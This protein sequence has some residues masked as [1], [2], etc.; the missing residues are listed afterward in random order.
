MKKSGRTTVWSVT[1]FTDVRSLMEGEMGPQ[2]AEEW[3]ERGQGLF[4]NWEWAQGRQGI[5]C[6]WGQVEMAPETGRLHFQAGCK[7]RVPC[8]L[9]MA[10][11]MFGES[12]PHMEAAIDEGALLNYCRKNHSA[13]SAPVMVINEAF[14]AAGLSR[15]LRANVKPLLSKRDYLFVVRRSNGQLSADVNLLEALFSAEGGKAEGEHV[16]A[17][18]PSKTTLANIEVSY[19][20][21]VVKKCENGGELTERERLFSF[22]P[23]AE[24]IVKEKMMAAESTERRDVKCL[25]LLGRPGTGKS[26]IANRLARTICSLTHRPAATVEFKKTGEAWW[27]PTIETASVAVLEEF[28]GQWNLETFNKVVDEFPYLA[29]YKGGNTYAKYNYVIITTNVHPDEWFRAE[30]V[31]RWG[32]QDQRLTDI[33]QSAIRSMRR[34][35]G[36]PNDT[37]IGKMIDFD[38][39]KWAAAA[40]GDW[41]VDTTEIFRAC[42]SHFD[43]PW[44]LEPS[45]RERIPSYDELLRRDMQAVID[46]MLEEQ[47]ELSKM[48]DGDKQYL[49]ANAALAVLL[50]DFHIYIAQGR[51]GVQKRRQQL[52]DPELDELLG[53]VDKKR[54]KLILPKEAVAPEPEAVEEIDHGE[55]LAASPFAF[56][57]DGMEHEEL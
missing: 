15:W 38:D 22:G 54:M 30:I 52:R 17:P 46:D 26:T 44:T 31:D 5:E 18:P 39:P 29:G 34:R 20:D 49:L 4:D 42:C 21:G 1:V 41:P 53:T 28:S 10:K 56:S 12:K 27:S 23:R 43:I 57:P 33:R 55:V 2:T 40:G 6:L 50:Q 13:L 3:C 19:F 16:E 11:R 24:K 48:G 37:A 8:G 32:Q 36:I 14:V 7:L 35:V 47:P 9:E 25:V 51:V 45:V